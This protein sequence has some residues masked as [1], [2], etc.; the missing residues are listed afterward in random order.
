MIN[1]TP[2][3][4]RSDETGNGYLCHH[5]GK[6]Y[7]D[8]FDALTCCFTIDADNI[9]NEKPQ[10]CIPAA[11][12]HEYVCCLPRRYEI[13]IQNAVKKVIQT[14]NPKHMTDTEYKTHM[15]NAMRSK[16]CDLT[17]TIQIIYT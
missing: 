16:V 14:I 17:D 7:E 13:R 9:Q 10:I 12:Q 8:E 1:E 15:D 2:T 5:C 3:I 11:Y 6:R 4:Y